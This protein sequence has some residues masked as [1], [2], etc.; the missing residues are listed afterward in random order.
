[1]AAGEDPAE[2]HSA[3]KNLPILGHLS[4]EELAQQAIALFKRAPPE[5][6][7]RHRDIEMHWCTTPPAPKH[8]VPRTCQLRVPHDLATPKAL[9]CSAQNCLNFFITWHCAV[10]TVIS[11]R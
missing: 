4:T 3:L 8:A 6:L 1:M 11:S 2:L 9:P 10:M 5:K 7:L